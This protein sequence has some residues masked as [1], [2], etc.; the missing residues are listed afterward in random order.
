MLLFASRCSNAEEGSPSAA[1]LRQLGLASMSPVSDTAGNAVRGKAYA[2]ISSR[3]TIN[4]P[5]IYGPTPTVGDVVDFEG[6]VI[7]G[8]SLST[9][10]AQIQIGTL[11]PAGNQAFIFTKQHFINGTTHVRG[12]FADGT[13]FTFGT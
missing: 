8:R 12:G 5:W 3:Y 13:V 7:S 9:Q 2:S 6:T 1:K 4:G 10:P 11:T